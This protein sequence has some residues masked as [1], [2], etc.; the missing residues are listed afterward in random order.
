LRTTAKRVFGREEKHRPPA[1]RRKLARTDGAESDTD[2]QIQ[3]QEAFAV[4]KLAAQDVDGLLDPEFLDQCSTIGFG[5]R[6]SSMTSRSCSGRP[7][8]G[9]WPYSQQAQV[10]GGSF[11]EFL[12]ERGLR[13]LGLPAALSKCLRHSCS[14]LGGRDSRGKRLG[15]RL[16]MGA[17]NSAAGAVNRR[18][19]NSARGVVKGGQNI[20]F[21]LLTIFGRPSIWLQ[22][23]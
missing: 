7:P 10:A 4:F 12:D 15:I 18:R 22:S 23:F 21:L 8:T 17:E 5:D 20:I 1:A 6:G 16:A 9:H 19:L 14:C 11:A 2:G 3:P 13:S